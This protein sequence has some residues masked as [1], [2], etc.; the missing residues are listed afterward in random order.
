MGTQRGSWPVCS[1]HVHTPVSTH[2]QA[3]A[4]PH[5]QSPQ[6]QSSVRRRRRRSYPGAVPGAWPPESP[7]KPKPPPPARPVRWARPCR[8]QAPTW[9]PLQ[10]QH[11]HPLQ[12]GTYHGRLRGRDPEPLGQD[13]G[14]VGGSGPVPQQPPVVQLLEWLVALV[15][16]F[17]LNLKDLVGVV[18][19]G[20]R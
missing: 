1:L 20:E 17:T 13:A 8:T 9:S 5:A 6:R 7:A 15:F 19:K 14:E 2:S 16:P 4:L 18:S 12:A 10:R 3:R 11:A